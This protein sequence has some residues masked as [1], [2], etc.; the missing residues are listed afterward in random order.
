MMP[1]T[2]K[3]S[4]SSHARRRYLPLCIALCPRAF[5]WKL[6]PAHEAAAAALGVLEPQ[7]YTEEAASVPS[8]TICDQGQSPDALARFDGSR[9]V[10]GTLRGRMEDGWVC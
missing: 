9:R 7:I 6:E 1:Q 3:D 5:P 8:A 4:Y 10:R 2:P